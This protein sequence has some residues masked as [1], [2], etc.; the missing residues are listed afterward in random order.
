M[1]STTAGDE[2]VV[3]DE[4]WDPHLLLNKLKLEH[5]SLTLDRTHRVNATANR[6]WP[7]DANDRIG[8]HQQFKTNYVAIPQFIRKQF[9]VQ[10]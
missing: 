10:I 4:P 7:L 2:E 1:G 8:D 5:P 3:G 6:N 9:G